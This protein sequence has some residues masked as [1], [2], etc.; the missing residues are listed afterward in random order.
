M[1]RA[2]IDGSKTQTRRVMGPGHAGDAV[3]A[4]AGS[5]D[6]GPRALLRRCPYGVAGD[7]LWVK[8]TWGGDDCCGFAYRAD[9]P[10]QKRF[11]GDG[12]QPDSPWRSPR[13]MPRAASRI[14]LEVVSVRVERLQ[15][16]T[17]D[18]ARA[19]AASLEGPFPS[20]YDGA[21]WY[22]EA[23]A[24]LWDGINSKRAPWAS[25]PWVWAITFKRVRP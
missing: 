12:E 6:A 16:I 14:D 2:I 20:P 22:R 8:E 23:F 7:R 18:D 3:R 19:E 11:E 24:V 15:E 10:E 1:V 25:N 9:T 4:A 21:R 5:L 17:E 13:F